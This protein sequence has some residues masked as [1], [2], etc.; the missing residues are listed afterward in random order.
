[1]PTIRPDPSALPPRKQPSVHCRGQG[2]VPRAPCLP[3][4]GRLLVPA[5]P[6]PG[7][8]R[9][10][11]PFPLREQVQ[12]TF[13]STAQKKRDCHSCGT[14]HQAL[15]TP[16][17]EPR[18]PLL[19]LPARCTPPGTWMPT[20]C[21]PWPVQPQRAPGTPSPAPRDLAAA[22][23][24]RRRGRGADTASRAPSPQPPQVSC[25]A[26]AVS[27]PRPLHRRTPWRP[28]GTSRTSQS[29]T[30]RRRPSLHLPPADH[31]R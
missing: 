20:P 7:P 14:E 31:T 13:R 21:P 16:A 9:G 27:A 22:A 12:R 18:Y 3:S 23:R 19:G 8:E 30:R 24:R 1:M 11:P 4:A 29:P 15:H 25:P 26:G 28:R 5:R 17:T 6:S 10:H 2:L